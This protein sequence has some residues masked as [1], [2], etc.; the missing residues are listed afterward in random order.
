M[1]SFGDEP[2]RTSLEGTAPTARRASRR[3]AGR[4]IA[5]FPGLE[6]STQP[7][8]VR[9]WSPLKTFGFI[10]GSGAV[11]WVLILGGLSLL[12]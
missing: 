6:T 11:L 10:F 3:K 1:T 2:L 12:R 9:G 8:S 5:P 4:L 7:Q